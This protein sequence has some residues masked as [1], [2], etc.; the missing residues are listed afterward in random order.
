MCKNASHHDLLKILL[1]YSKFDQIHLGKD[2][3]NS[4]FT[5]MQNLV[6][7]AVNFE[8]LNLSPKAFL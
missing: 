8:L 7:K 2:Q 4:N 1:L 5:F 6:Y 3:G